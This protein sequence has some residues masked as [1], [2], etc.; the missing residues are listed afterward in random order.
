[1]YC[2]YFIYRGVLTPEEFVGAGDL[3]VATC[4]TWAW[5]GGDP[6]HAKA[7]LPADKQFLITRGVPSY[8]RASDMN[9]DELRETAADGVG[10]DVGDDHWYLSDLVKTG[11]VAAAPVDITDGNT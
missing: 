8:R 6:A 7:H 4:P 10:E 11:V 9:N 3:I 1:L 2:L 5:S